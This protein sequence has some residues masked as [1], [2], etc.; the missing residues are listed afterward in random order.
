M[1]H[2]TPFYFTQLQCISQISS[3]HKEM[4]VFLGD[5]AWGPNILVGTECG[6]AAE[7]VP[8]KAPFMP[9]R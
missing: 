8:N 2:M 3:P 7:V 1:R 9:K 6:D 4:P 5:R